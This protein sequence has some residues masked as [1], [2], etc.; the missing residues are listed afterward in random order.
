VAVIAVGVWAFAPARQTDPDAIWKQAEAD[1]HNHQIDRAEVGLKRLGTL[2][3][4]TPL[5]WML[6]AQVAMARDRVEAALSDLAKVPDDHAMAAQ[7]RLSAGQLELRRGRPR[8]AETMFKAAIAIDPKL[9][10]AHRE[11]IYIY[12]VLLRRSELNAEFLALS[13]LAPMT[14]DNVW[15]WCLTRNSAWEPGELTKQLED[16]VKNDPEDRNSRLALADNYRALNRRDDAAKVLEYLGDADPDARALR[17]RLALDVGD[18]EKAEAMLKDGP[19]DHADLARLRGK[20]ALARRDGPAAVVAF[21]A[22]YKADPDHRDALFGLGQALAMTD[23]TEAAKPFIEAARNHEAFASLMQRV[24][25]R[26]NRGDASL[27]RALGAA[28][29]KIHRIPE[30]RAWYRL[31]IDLNPLD[32]AAQKALYRLKDAGSDPSVSSG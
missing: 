12:G 24:S 11:L 23:E 4:P 15:H 21:R 27:L 9:V 29:E 2:R 10:Q 18:D 19:T 16:Y 22:A 6:R 1:I 31:A 30:A 5:D 25:A 3:A 13:K 14:F 8:A 7:A 32:P 17:V 26:Q 28:S 20:L